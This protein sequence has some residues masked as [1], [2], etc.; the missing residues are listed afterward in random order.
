[1]PLAD[2]AALSLLRL[3]RAQKCWR[4]LDRKDGSQLPVIAQDIPSGHF[5]ASTGSLSPR[6]FT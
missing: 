1:M 3:V 6:C 4:A 5:W 2:G